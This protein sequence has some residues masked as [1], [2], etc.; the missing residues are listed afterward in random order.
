[1]TTTILIGTRNKGK[2]REFLEILADSPYRIV[3]PD[4]IGLQEKPEEEAIES[5]ETFEGNALKKAQYFARRSGLPTAADDSGLEVISLGGAPGVRSRRF[6]P[7]AADQ[8]AANNAELLKR[9]QGAGPERRRARYRAV[10]SYLARPDAMPRTFEGS[11]SGTI[12]EAPRGTGG[13]GYDPLFVSDE[14]QET[15]GETTSE[16]KHAISHRGRAVRE[17]RTWLESH[18]PEAGGD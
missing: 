4:D 12:A 7:P 16:A 8:D 1:V 5:A 6:A 17:F 11:C 15:F 9:L 2:Q 13:F 3:F 10:I 14:L 18:L